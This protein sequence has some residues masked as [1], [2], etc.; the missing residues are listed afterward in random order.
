MKAVFFTA[1]ALTAFAFNS[2]LCRL[3]L[4]NEA[5]DA[6]SFTVIR[7]S[8]GAAV[9]VVI[10]AVYGKKTEIR[11]KG[12]WISAFFLFLYAVGFSLAYINLTTATGALILFGFVQITMI[13]Y[14][15]LTGEKPRL[16]DW[17]GLTAA[18]AG[19]ICLVYPG[20]SAPPLVSSLLMALAGIAWGMYTLRGKKS[21]TPLADTTGNFLRS[22]PMLALIIPLLFI[23]LNM[24][25]K[26]ILLA[27]LSGA[28]ASG[29]GYSVWYAALKFHTATRAA[30]LQLSVP[31]LAAIGGLIFASE[32]ISIRLFMAAVLILGGIAL[33]IANGSNPRGIKSD[34]LE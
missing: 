9:L 27:V 4:G 10:S 1:F 2:I 14:A 21:V 19:L 20:L 28:V 17:L 33:T 34:E 13:L 18:L 3:A 5:I 7:L 24:S 12:N 11:K 22:I 8:S 32:L 25:I 29:V 23:D 15:V 16:F 31:V 26:G 30:V 6:A